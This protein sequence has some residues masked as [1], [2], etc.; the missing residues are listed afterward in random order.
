MP[1][2]K[3][4][5]LVLEIDP[6][7]I[8]DAVEGIQRFVLGSDTSE[9]RLFTRTLHVAVEDKAEEVLK[10]FEKAPLISESEL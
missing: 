6:E 7:R 5:V 10:V 3:K 9:P 1:D 2:K 4:A 8:S